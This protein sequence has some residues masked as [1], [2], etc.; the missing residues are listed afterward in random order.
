MGD[1]TL[2]QYRDEVR[3]H[4]GGRTDL[5]D[6]K[7]TRAINIAQVQLARIEDFEEL[8]ILAT[9]AIPFTNTNADRFL[10]KTAVSGTKT[11]REMISFVVSDGSSRSRKLE[12]CTPRQLDRFIGDATNDLHS[13]FIPRKYVMWDD[14]MELWPLPDQ[15]YSSIIR[16]TIWPTALALGGDKSIFV[17]KDEILI[18]LTTSYMYHSLGEYDRAKM[19]FGFATANIA[20][21]L[22]QD[23]KS[24]DRDIKPPWESL[25]RG[26]TGEYWLNPFVRR[27][28]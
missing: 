25:S 17:F 9:P 16:A 26:A 6:A 8:R 12:Q 5:S 4:L 19:F 15:A 20:T 1:L 24:P 18:H 14:N 10:A 28:P 27:S 21:A 23:K 11:L 7:L 22:L 3:D 13:R 2:S